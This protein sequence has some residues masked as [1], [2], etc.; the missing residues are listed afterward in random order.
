[1]PLNFLDPKQCALLVVDIQERLMPVIEGR[2]RVVKNSQLL[3]K[4]ARSLHM[5]IIATTQYA[6][7]IG[8]LLQQI[9]EELGDIVPVDKMEFGC[10]ANDNF[11]KAIQGL[12][13]EI[14]TF[15]VCGVETHI[16]IYQTV[17]GGLISGYK[18]LVSSDSVSSRTGHNYSNGLDRIRE[19]G[20]T[21]AS[22]EM[23]IYELLGKAGTPE[24][25]ALLPFLK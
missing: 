13:P 14:T 23:I 17:L 11:K 4:T 21:V 6:A 2:D 24:F 18:M 5:P 3:I 9:T 1:M 7:R 8:P 12:S 22:T 19:V 10:F 20:G 15:L 16:C 25:K